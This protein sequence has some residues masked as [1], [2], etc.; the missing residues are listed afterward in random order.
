MHLHKDPRILGLLIF[1]KYI[2]SKKQEKEKKKF[3]LAL[4]GQYML[5]V[6]QNLLGRRFCVFFFVRKWRQLKNEL[7][8]VTK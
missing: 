1:A 5:S 8:K 6:Q 7:S 2:K 3:Y 4:E